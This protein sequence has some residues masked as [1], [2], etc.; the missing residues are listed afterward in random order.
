[1]DEFYPVVFITKSLHPSKNEYNSG[2]IYL[3]ALL[4]FYQ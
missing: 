3:E 4:S 2:K 1:M